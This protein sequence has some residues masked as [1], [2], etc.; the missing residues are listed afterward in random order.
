[1][2]YVG[3]PT[4]N[5]VTDALAYAGNF[6]DRELMLIWPN[7]VRF[8][9]TTSTNEEM[10]AAAYA[11]G[12]R[13]KIDEEQGWH[14][15]ISNVAVQGVVGLSKDVHWDLQDSDTE[16]NI[17]NE[18]N[19]TT[20]IQSNGFRFWGSRTCSTEENFAF[21]SATRTAQILADS[22]AES[23]MWAVDKPLLPGLVRDILEGVNAKFRELKT[24]GYI[25]DA[26][27][28]YNEDVNSTATL[29]SGKLSID[30]DYTPVP[31]LE[32]LLFRQAI[33]DTYFADFAT[34]IA[35]GT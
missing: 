8:N 24:A 11:L 16:A 1:M 22:I 21:E 30:Y 20:L 18:A 33:T 2:A 13:A 12:M 35:S 32:N 23:H 29:K 34:R 5:N 19:I 25:I 3:C 4:V 26:T 10:P 31:P 27:A 14:K 15:T 9:S 28:V 6:G 7:F 17:L